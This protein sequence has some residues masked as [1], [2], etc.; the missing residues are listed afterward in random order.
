[1]TPKEEK[2][3]R[4]VPWA[5]HNTAGYTSRYNNIF[6]IIRRE[7]QQV[8]TYV[9]NRDKKYAYIQNQLDVHMFTF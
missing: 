5:F 3:K 1:M 2:G 6:I 4:N 9:S 7:H 8:F